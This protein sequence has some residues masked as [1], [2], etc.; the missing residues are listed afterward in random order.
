MVIPQLLADGAVQEFTL[1]N[2]LQI[3]GMVLIGAIG[4]LLKM[5]VTDM[6]NELK[7]LSKRLDRQCARLRNVELDVAANSGRKVRPMVDD[8]DDTDMYDE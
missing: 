1:S 5:G 6:K 4:T 8:V 2:A 3:I 7:G